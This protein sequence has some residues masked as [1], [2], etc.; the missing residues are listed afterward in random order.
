MSYVMKYY[1]LQSIDFF[2]FFLVS[3]GLHKINHKIYQNI[4]AMLLADISAMIPIGT[5]TPTRRHYGLSFASCCSF[6]L[7]VLKHSFF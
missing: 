5:E 4:S 7:L 1:G 2:F 3:V 6:Y